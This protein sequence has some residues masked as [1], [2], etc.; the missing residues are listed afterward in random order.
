VGTIDGARKALVNESGE[1]AA[2]VDMRVR[3]DDGVYQRGVERERAVT[4]PGFVTLPMV[5][6][7]IEENGLPFV[8]EG[9]H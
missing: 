5:H 2:V 9:M 7:T 4:F 3:Q 8:R 1:V 6:A